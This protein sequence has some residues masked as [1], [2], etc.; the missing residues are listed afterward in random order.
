MRKLLSITLLIAALGLGAVTLADE[1]RE[2]GKI[3]RRGR[4]PEEMKQLA[5]L[6]GNWNVQLQ[7]RTDI[8]GDEWLESTAGTTFYYAV[9]GSVLQMEYTG[10]VGN[11]MMYGLSAYC[12]DRE[13]DRWQYSWIDNIGCRVSVF[14]GDYQGDSLTFVGEGSYAGMKSLSR[15]SH[16]NLT[17]TGFD[18]TLE[19]SP[20]SGQTWQLLQ[21]AKFTKRN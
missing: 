2:S 11:L 3:D 8:T 1:I 13:T 7:Y 9:R 6:V 18:W 12:Y 16:L 19:Q 5:F 14:E 21:K 20:D 4:A 17:P 15:I 10:Q